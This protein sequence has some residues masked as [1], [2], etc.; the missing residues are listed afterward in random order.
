MDIRHLRI[1]VAVAKCSSTTAAANQLF[2][3]QSTVSLAISELEN[4]Y[5]VHL[6]DR[7]NRKLQLNAQGQL[8]LEHA[9]D[10]LNRFSEMEAAI[11]SQN[12]H[13]N[14]HLGLS[15]GMYALLPLCLE[16][17]NN[18]Y[19]DHQVSV[20]IDNSQLIKQQLQ[21]AEIDLG[22][23][24]ADLSKT[25]FKSQILWQD[26]MSFFCAPN[27]PLAAKT[28]LKFT[29]LAD[30]P[31][32]L[33]EKGCISRHLFEKLCRKYKLN[34]K[35][36]WQSVSNFSIVRAI[37]DLNGIMISP[38]IEVEKNIANKEIVPLNI[39]EEGLERQVLLAYKKEKILNEQDKTFIEICR[40]TAR[41][42]YYD[43]LV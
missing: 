24:A 38:F 22:I 30:Y 42:L 29:D 25:E 21:N 4:H 13:D 5:Q 36:A 41:E 23:L 3:S 31:F 20:T 8:L 15:I 16:R 12:Y 33:R 2:I 9:Q 35:P 27:H 1:F 26:R 7:I 19:P 43:Y 18:I 28:D 37:K 11:Q 39:E 17:F 10:I 40:Q 32:L 6:F 14:L 34:L